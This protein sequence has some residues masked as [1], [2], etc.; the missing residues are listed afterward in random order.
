M[1]R[2]PVI[3]GRE[4][5][6]VF[7]RAGFEV[8]R[9]QGSHIILSKAGFSETLSVPDPYGSNSKLAMPGPR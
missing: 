1:P 6:A 8:K 4:A 9:Q 2:L 3:S 7:R 5:V